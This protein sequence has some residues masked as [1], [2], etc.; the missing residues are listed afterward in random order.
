MDALYKRVLPQ[1]ACKRGNFRREFIWE[2][3]IKINGSTHKNEPCPRFVCK[4]N[5]YYRMGHLIEVNQIR[6]K[7]VFTHNT[8]TVFEGSIVYNSK[9]RGYIDQDDNLKTQYIMI[10]FFGISGLT[11]VDVEEGERYMN[12]MLNEMKYE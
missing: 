9:F 3:F 8:Y 11:H 6:N 1:I 4:D 5:S 7:A 12:D 2:R 10:N